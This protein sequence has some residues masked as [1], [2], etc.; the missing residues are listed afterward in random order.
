MLLGKKGA[1]SGHDFFLY[2]RGEAIRM[3]HW[4]YRR[5][6]ERGMWSHSSR[7]ARRNDTLPNPVVIQLFNLEDDPGETTNL[8]E[9][10]PE[11]VSEMEKE[12]QRRLVE[13]TP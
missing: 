4:K 3:G 2:D 12:L 11:K 6:K 10:F 9:Q 8:A 1:S 5:G 7:E 13:I